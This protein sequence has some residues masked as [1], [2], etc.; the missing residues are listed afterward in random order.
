MRNGVQIAAI[1]FGGDQESGLRPGTENTA[2]VVGAATSIVHAQESLTSRTLSV[3]QKR[4]AFITK[5]ETIEGLVLNGS[6]KE[7]VA[8][9][10]NISI[11]GI[12]SEFAVISLDQ[13]GVAC[14]TKSACGGAKGDGSS[15]VREITK[16]TERALSTIRFT[17]GEE[18]TLAELDQTFQYLN[19]HVLRT[20][21]AHKKLTQ[22]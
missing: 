11:A 3:S 12:D 15:V 9:N 16:D 6:R 10:V 4:D 22:S 21:A 20:R 13:K 14:A 2:L 18:T 1:S 7:R 5:L 19:E 17:L 8:N